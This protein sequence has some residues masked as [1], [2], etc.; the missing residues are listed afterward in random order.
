MLVSKKRLYPGQK[1]SAL[2]CGDYRSEIT[3]DIDWAG[4]FAEAL[5][6]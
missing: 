6:L 3:G 5:F 2:F 1:V 4:D